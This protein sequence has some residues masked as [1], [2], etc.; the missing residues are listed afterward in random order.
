M[1]RNGQCINGLGSF[2]CL[3][4]EGYEN[5][6][7]GKNCVG[8]SSAKSSRVGNQVEVRSGQKCR[9]VT[10]SSCLSL[11]HHAVRNQFRLVDA[12]KA[13]SKKFSQGFQVSRKVSSR[14]PKRARTRLEDKEAKDFKDSGKETSERRV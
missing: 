13:G 5:T 4:H 10:G 8:E 12:H 6:P 14:H 1:C 7:D 9:A 11:V 3:C 2:Q